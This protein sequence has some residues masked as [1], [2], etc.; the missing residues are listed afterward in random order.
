MRQ[1]PE[2]VWR[3][4][5]PRP[6]KPLRAGFRREK[7]GINM[8]ISYLIQ[9]QCQMMVYAAVGALCRRRGVINEQSEKNLSAAIIEIVLPCTIF[10]AMLEGLEQV[11]WARA[12]LTLVICLALHLCSYGLGLVLYRRYPPQ[13]RAVCVFGLL[14][15]NAAFVGLPM[16]SGIYGASGVFYTTIFMTISRIFMWGPGLRL[17]P[18]SGGGSAVRAVLTNP[19]TIAM[20]LALGVYFLL[21]FQ[22][23]AFALNAVREIGSVSTVLCMAMVGSLLTGLTRADVF[24]PAVLGYCLLRL[25]LL[26]LAVFSVLSGLKLNPEIVGVLTLLSSA[27][28]PTTGSVLAAR[29]G[30]DKKLAATL[31]LVSTALSAATIPAIALLYA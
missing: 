7:Q 11:D 16:V 24:R 23:P 9:T 1:T 2:P 3:R 26:P 15:N 19:N 6:N 29:Y 25:V 4:C 13:R 20:F 28:G 17:F 27:P 30:G 18:E 5:G 14:V 22:L 10:N 31:A 21:P 8:G 12:G